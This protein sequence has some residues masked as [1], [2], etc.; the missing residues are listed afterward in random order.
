MTTAGRSGCARFLPSA[1]IVTDCL[2]DVHESATAL[3]H[4][5]AVA[6]SVP[7]DGQLDDF[8]QALARCSADGDWA[9][10]VISNDADTECLRAALHSVWLKY[11]WA[12]H[13][14]FRL[15][16]A[17]P[18]VSGR[19]DEWSMSTGRFLLGM[20]AMFRT[21]CDTWPDE[22]QV[23]ELVAAVLDSHY[24]AI[25][26]H[27]DSVTLL[28]PVDAIDLL[29]ATS[30]QDCFLAII[31][32]PSPAAA[33]YLVR[34]R[35]SAG[36]SAL[37]IAVGKD[38]RSAAVAL[39]NLGC[40]S[41][42]FNFDLLLQPSFAPMFDM[43]L[44]PWQPLPFD[45]VSSA[46]VIARAGRKSVL[47]RL[48][49]CRVDVSFAAGDYPLVEAC[50]TGDEDVV[51]CVLDR[52]SATGV[53]AFRSARI[54]AEL[55]PR[56][57]GAPDPLNDVTRW[58]AQRL[59]DAIID[60]DV[61]VALE[62]ALLKRLLPFP[63]LMRKALCVVDV[64]ADTEPQDLV[65]FFIDFDPTNAVA[66]RASI[67][68]VRS[69]VER[70]PRVDED[71]HAIAGTM[72][73]ACPAAVPMLE[74][75][76]TE[77]LH[78]DALSMTQRFNGSTLLMDCGLMPPQ[79]AAAQCLI[80][81]SEIHRCRDRFVNQVD[82]RGNNALVRFVIEAA[83]EPARLRT[84]GSAAADFVRLLLQH[85]CS[86]VVRP[87]AFTLSLFEMMVRHAS[88]PDTSA[89]GA[90][91]FELLPTHKHRTSL[92]SSTT[93][94]AQVGIALQ[95]MQRRCGNALDARVAATERAVV[96]LHVL[97]QLLAWLRGADLKAA[98][99]ATAGFYFAAIAASA[100]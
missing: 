74:T 63:E 83:Q 50:S 69:V 49:D 72:I 3:G 25:V 18:Y 28:R 65:A 45:A 31:T 15:W 43:L 34:C 41:E 48:F 86:A 75:F 71:I 40:R 44:D 36:Q 8:K 97:A 22:F 55:L 99:Q 66:K 59:G 100:M 77:A 24:Y 12:H 7:V 4:A 37:D 73:R 76:L 17:I 68:A 9:V 52:M 29:G 26:E 62:A 95:A 20:T 92:I 32:D 70:S 57:I 93:F 94:D 81:A 90:V 47:Q 87:P 82:E 98:A 84:H 60:E 79:V 10:I 39:R 61:K 14:R 42:V 53:N 16:I 56:V 19:L 80:T 38:F 91:C 11:T 35:D 2:A 13:E 58:V 30:G 5:P 51:L 21:F 89:C 27:R 46:R 88:G 96:P 54:A 23:R 78:V 64:E 67:R 33:D 85:E 1:A 6:I